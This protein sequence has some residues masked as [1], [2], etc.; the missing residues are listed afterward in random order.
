LRALKQRELCVDG[1]FEKERLVKKERNIYGSRNSHPA[2]TDRDEKLKARD[3]P[4]QKQKKRKT[5]FYR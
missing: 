5:S 1:W 2:G 3:G 4:C